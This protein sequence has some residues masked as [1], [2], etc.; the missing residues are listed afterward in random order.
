MPE[1]AVFVAHNDGS[2]L[3]IRCAGCD[4]DLGSPVAAR[5]GGESDEALIERLLEEAA[6]GSECPTPLPEQLE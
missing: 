6:T 3:H 4:A 2:R 1:H 5:R